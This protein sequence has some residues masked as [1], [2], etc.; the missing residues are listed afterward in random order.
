[1]PRAGGASR[2]RREW[3]GRLALVLLGL[4]LS[5]PAIELLLQLGALFNRQTLG[6]GASE[7][8]TGYRRVLALGDSNTFGLRV[9]RA[10]AYPK[11]LERMWNGSHRTPGRLQVLNAGYPGMTSTT[12]RGTVVDFIRAFR[13]DVVT[14]MVGA[15]DAWT[16]Y[17]PLAE[18]TDEPTVREWLWDHSRAY[19]LAFMIGKWFEHP[20]LELE[21]MEQQYA[22]AVRYGDVEFSVRQVRLK[23]RPT[24]EHVRENLVAIGTAARE[25]GARVY[26]LTFPYGMGWVHRPA[27]LTIRRA[28]TDT[29]LPL[30]DVNT[31]FRQR[32]Y[33]GCPDLIFQN[34]GHPTV[35]G[36]RLA[37][38]TI[39]HGLLHAPHVPDS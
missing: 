35:E 10:N 2:S 29:D 12:V 31:V 20:V 23:E 32:C 3:G 30:I 19:R 36:H 9:G 38:K 16:A 18:R 6:P 34:D 1:M 17:E 33:A 8:M 37:A 28:A 11:V 21:G 24:W 4:A 26:F 22:T 14:V 5:L 15:N 27:N 39:L 25:H 13:P 7:G